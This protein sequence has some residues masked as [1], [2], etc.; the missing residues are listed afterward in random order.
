M[1]P[2]A[3]VQQVIDD[4]KSVKIQWATNIARAAFETLIEQSQTD[5]FATKDEFLKFIRTAMELLIGARPTEPMLFNGMD[6][7]TSR[8]EQISKEESL[9]HIKSLI[10]ESVQFYLNL[11][12]ETADRAVLNSLWII[13]DGDN[14]LTHCHSSSAVNTLKLHKTKGLQFKVY[15]TE[16]RPLFQGRRT[17]RNLIQAWID[18]TMV[19]DGAAPFLM[20][21]ESGTDIKMD[22]VIIGCDAIK[23][24]GGVI[25]KI[26]S[27]SIGL[28]ALYSNIPLYIAGNLLKTDIH[29]TIDIE[30][31]ESKEVWGEAPEGLN[32]L[33]LAFDKIPA[34]FIRG[35][36]T[37]F[38]IIKPRDLKAVIEKEYP[39]MKIKKN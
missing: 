35:I 9:E 14:V 37:E 19:V 1:N 6:Y 31:R 8:L 17:A 26:G 13:H 16:T 4:I 23:L 3:I 34:K 22:C 30:I 5:F 15:N 29:D 24:D 10:K 28:S 21:M 38:G 25:N 20:D 33:N 11:I 27:Y 36:I 18:T 7:I 2:T 39:W 12:N 32:F